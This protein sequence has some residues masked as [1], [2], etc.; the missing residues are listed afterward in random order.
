MAP[1]KR[2]RFSFLILLTRAPARLETRKE[3]QQARWRE[4][5]NSLGR[6][7]GTHFGLRAQ[8]GRPKVWAH[9]SGEC[10]ITDAVLHFS[11]ANDR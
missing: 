4:R 3:D 6:P 8:F 2:H 7:S 1:W 9:A 5:S 10:A 11:H